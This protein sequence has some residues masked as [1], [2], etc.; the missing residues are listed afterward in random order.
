ML[1]IFDLSISNNRVQALYRI[2]GMYFFRRAIAGEKS[3]RDG[4]SFTYRG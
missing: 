1:V 4:N 2:G 3:D